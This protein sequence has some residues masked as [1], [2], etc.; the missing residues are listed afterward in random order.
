MN[1]FRSL[2]C[3]ECKKIWDRKLAKISFALCLVLVIVTGTVRLFGSYVV[4][5]EVIGSEYD[6]IRVDQSYAAKL[7]NRAINQQLLEEMV[8]AYR[9]IPDTPGKHYTSSPEYQKYARPYSEIFNF[10]VGSTN[11]LASDVFLNWEPNE[12]DLY[13]QRN[14][15]LQKNWDNMK[16]SES[17]I[18]FWQQRENKIE[19]PIVFQPHEGYSQ[20][21]SAYQTIAF[22]V[23][24]FVSIALSGI[25]PEEHSRRTDQLVLSSP[26]GRK[27]LYWAKITAG[28]SY[29]A[30]TTL[31]F[32][33]VISLLMFSLYGSEGF[34]AAFQL[35][36][37]SNSDPIT[38]GQA[39][40]IAY[41]N[42]MI[43]AIFVSIIVMLLS[44]LLH[45]SMAALAISA[46]MLIASMVV[47]V[48]E[49]FRVFAQIWNWLPWSF[50]NPWNVFG[51]YTL[52]VSGMHL[53][54]WQ[55]VPLIYALLSVAVAWGGKL[56]YQRYQV[57]GR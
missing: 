26:M 2:Y 22:L 30:V 29:A 39:L 23:I 25:F 56:I 50:L 24:L 34:G 51:E 55:S 9:K 19:K 44:E 12:Q 33:T 47:S 4:D 21:F 38:C 31:A 52:S 11:L 27:K 36:Y 15:W 18:N 7:D 40:L 42:M 16:L 3:Y 46:G 6:E 45:S 49:Y 5:G 43:A 53:T 14:I 1:T 57:S 37:K 54:P 32:F 17:E 10:V 35:H 13:E 8:T 28:V 48:P 41:A 20:M